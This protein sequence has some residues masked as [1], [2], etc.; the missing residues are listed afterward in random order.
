MVW[1]IWALFSAV[2]D[3]AHYLLVRRYVRTI[4][5]YALA[6]GTI[7]VSAALLFLISLLRGMPTV[8]PGFVPALLATVA[9]NVI[10]TI[11]TYW[12]LER[13]DVSLA[14]PMIAFTPVFTILTSFIILQEFPTTIGISGILLLAIGS[15]F[16][17]RTQNGNGLL[18]PFKNIV[19]N[20]GVLAMLVVGLLYSVAINFDKQVVLHS[21]PI[22]GGAVIEALL[23]VIFLSIAFLR[24]PAV[25]QIYRQHTSVFIITGSVLA[26][27]GITVNTALSQQIV[28][29]VISIK[30]LSILLTVIGG[31]VF[32]HEKNMISK[33]VG[34]VIMVVGVVMII[35]S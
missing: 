17:Q 11:L 32:F 31:G 27:I 13:S 29:Y 12:A 7:L 2:F 34:A 18:A 21:D 28:P 30:R 14:H 23:G 35:F 10:A 33:I 9:I 20:K 19:K 15:Y 1:Y 8:T 26:L 25:G 24:V 22:F 4:D 6:S 3:A 5:K 16:L